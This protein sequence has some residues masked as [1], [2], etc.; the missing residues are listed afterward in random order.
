MIY[1]VAV[2]KIRRYWYLI[3]IGLA[4]AGGIFW[5][6]RPKPV[7][8]KEYTVSKQPLAVTLSSSGTIV[9]ERKADLTF[10]TGGRLSWVGVKKGDWVK[11][12]QGIASLDK[13]QLEK[14][15]QKELNDYLTSRWNFQDTRDAYTVSTDNLDA[16]TLT[17]AARRVLERS[18]FTLN[19]SVL[20]VEIQMVSKEFASLVAPFDG[21]VTNLPVYIG[22][23]VTST[24]A[25][26]TVVDPDSMYFEAQVDEVDI[27]KVKVGAAVQLTLDAYPEETFDAKVTDIDFSPISLSG[28]GTGYAVKISLPPQTDDLKFKLGLNGNA[29]IIMVE[30]D[31]ALTLPPAAVAQKDGRWVVK[32]RRG[33]EI[34]EQNVEIGWETED[35]VEIKSGLTTGDKVYVNK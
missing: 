18:Q 3:L 24:T 33:K 11:K 23:N 10:Q 14:N 4:I 13:R 2:K 35:K 26:A 8:Y 9:P 5:W 1:Y 6:R 31:E 7:H 29:D 30:L 25:I 17:T 20:D 16:Y 21:M 32:V 19:N 28:G 15:L 22:T 27:A 34:A 12:W